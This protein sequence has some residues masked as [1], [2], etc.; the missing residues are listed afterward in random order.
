M[1][2]KKTN[3]FQEKILPILHYIGFI[4]AAICSVAYI[5][6]V[7]ILIFGF[8]VETFL[9]TT[10]FACINAGVGFIIMQFLKYQGITFAELLP[11]NEAILKEYRGRKT[12]DKKNYSLTHFWVVSTIK[13]AIIK[14]LMLALTTI[15]LIYIVIQGSKDFNLIWLA[16][17]NLLLFISFGLL[18]LVKAYN[19]F[20]NNYIEYVK[21]QLKE[22]E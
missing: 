7:V 2:E 13:D 6:L 3:F 10:V 17:V 14:C 21:E 5:I 15:G 8:K 20:N 12:K 22:G 4:G 16:I 19:N 11:E 9:N 1:D 18:A